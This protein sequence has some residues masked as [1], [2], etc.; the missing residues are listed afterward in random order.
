[1]RSDVALGLEGAI[2]RTALQVAL[3]LQEITRK[4]LL[5]AKPR[6]PPES[7]DFFIK[8]LLKNAISQVL[9]SY[10]LSVAY[11]TIKEGSCGGPVPGVRSQV[12]LGLPKAIIKKA[13]HVAL[14]WH[15]AITRKA[16]LPAEPQ[17]SPESKDFCLKGILKNAISQVLQGY[18]LSVAYSTIKEGSCGG[19]VRRA[20]PQRAVASGSGFAK[21]N[22]KESSAC[23]SGFARQA[24]TRKALL[25]AEP[26]RSPESKDFFL[27]GI[28]KNAISQVLQGY[29]FRWLIAQL[30]REAAKA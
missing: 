13:L 8:G 11:S 19:L 2:I 24:I 26:Q 6:K 3:G 17:R 18:P 29:P 16:L 22:H 15:E 14:G 10:P 4:A 25:P 1:M 9:Q 7:N 5:P 23:G 28:L 30:K 21:S 20:R 27:K 12:A